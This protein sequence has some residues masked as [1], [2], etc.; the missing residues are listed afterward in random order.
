[1]PIKNLKNFIKN[2]SENY[3]KRNFKEDL[4]KGYLNTDILYAVKRL[5]LKYSNFLE[6]GCSGGNGLKKFKS[7]IFDWNKKKIQYYGIDVSAKAIQYAK[8]KFSDIKFYKLSSLE[9]GKLN[10]KFD[11]I[12]LGWMMYLLDREEIFNQFNILYKNLNSNGYLS[13]IDFQ[14]SFPHVNINEHSKKFF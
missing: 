11:M 9:I 10:I 7:S 5:N 12:N 2:D 4:T 6:I 13:I 1:M 3:F 8:K 14:P